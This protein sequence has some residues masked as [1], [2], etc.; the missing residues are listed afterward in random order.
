MRRIL[1]KLVELGI[2]HQNPWTKGWFFGRA[3]YTV[4]FPYEWLSDLFKRRQMCPQ[5]DH[6]ACGCGG[7]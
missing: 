1:A 6:D 2:V 3:P 4:S 5:D 7:L